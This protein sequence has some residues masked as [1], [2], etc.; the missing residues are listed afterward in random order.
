MN[1][2]RRSI[3]LVVLTSAVLATAMVADA[4]AQGGIN[5]GFA[6]IQG[7][8]ARHHRR[9]NT[10]MRPN[11]SGA[12]NLAMIR[13][14]FNAQRSMQQG[15]QKIAMELRGTKHILQLAD[16]DYQ[17]H[18]ARAVAS[19]DVAL[20]S[21][22]Q[23]V[24]NNGTGNINGNGAGAGRIAGG[25]NRVNGN[26]NGNRNAMREPQ[27][28]SDAQLRIALKRLSVIHSQMGSMS[29]GQQGQAGVAV[30]RAMHELNTALA[31]R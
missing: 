23:H 30:Q 6:G 14:G 24:G 5:G 20:R 7:A 9:N 28:K 16:H 4:R 18:R 2:T 21:M 8:T 17:G 31:I 22:G 29:N 1:H 26:R 15:Q 11:N 12:N 10:S 19:I 13:R 27:A 25:G 3:R